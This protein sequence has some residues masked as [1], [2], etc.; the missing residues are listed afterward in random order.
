MTTVTTGVR[1]GPLAPLAGR[2][3]LWFWLAFTVST[4]GISSQALGAQWF[5]VRDASSAGLVAL[6]QAAMTFPLAILS[7]PA[8]VLAD[9]FDRRS[10]LIAVQVAGLVAGAV[11]TWLSWTG[12]LGATTLLVLTFALGS[13]YAL[14][15]TP[16]QAVVPDVVKRHH[17]HEAAALVSIA[18]NTARVVGPALAG[19]L[20]ARVDIP[21]VF[22][23]STLTSLFFVIVLVR[24][25]GIRRNHA[26]HE[27]FLPAIRSGVR[28]VRH[29]PQVLKLMLRAFWFTA[30]MMATFAL[31]PLV[32]T[33]QLHAAADV[34]GI[35]FACLGA[36]AVC[37][38]F[39]I[40]P[41]R[42]WLT[43][44]S[45]VGLGFLV[46]ASMVGLLPL[47][48]GQP[49]AMACLFV[50]G[51]AWTICLSTMAGN[52]QIY[53]PA[54]VRARGLAIY[55]IALFSGQAAGS[56]VLGV[57]VDEIGLP[58]TLWVAAAFLLLGVSLTRWVPFVQLDDVDRTPTAYWHEPVLVV[59]TEEIGGEV[60]VAVE[61]WVDP[62]D[63]QQFRAGMRA[64]RRVRM[65]TGATRWRLLRD[66]EAHRRYV[67]EFTV[68]SWDEHER[69]LHQRLVASDTISESVVTA[70]SDPPP[71]VIHLFRIGLGG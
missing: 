25:P 34:Y 66:A 8:G 61:Y 10:L 27:R 16:F 18:A 11:L 46:A 19:L 65:R 41:L 33:D 48:P 21:A 70:L 50:A 60:V 49:A 30:G 12:A 58:R 15:L 39:S 7:L 5:L 44:N 52:L 43:E 13:V 53:L 68:S 26:R 54:W 71:R 40:A 9:R 31:L 1:S 14:T 63:E 29:S 3:F 59:P 4:I 69:Q 23:L 17:L 42:A 57:L 6:V 35:L 67:E 55:A 20:V 62:A 2:T 28:Y 56:V 47:L 51:W 37:G 32:A 36:G 24:W 22:A 64:V 45:I 38:G